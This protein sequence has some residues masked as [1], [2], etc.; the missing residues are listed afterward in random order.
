MYQDDIDTNDTV[1]DPIM[2]EETDDPTESLQVP[3]NE[4]KEEM[5]AIALDDLERGNDDMRQTIEDRDEDMGQ[6]G[7][8]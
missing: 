6:G 3:A 5:D 4:F 2:N 1:A 7:K 8:E